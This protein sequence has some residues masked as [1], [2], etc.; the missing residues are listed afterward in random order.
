MK[1]IFLIFILLFVLPID[2]KADIIKYKWYQITEENVSYVKEN[3]CN[4]I[5]DKKSYKENILYENEIDTDIYENRSDVYFKKQTKNK[6][7]DTEYIKYVGIKNA[8]SFNNYLSLSNILIFNKDTGEELTYNYGDSNNVGNLNN[9]IATK[10]HLVFFDNGYLLLVLDNK[11]HKDKLE[12][13]LNFNN[14]DFMNLISL[15]ASSDMNISTYT[16]TLNNSTPKTSNHALDSFN[17]TT[18]YQVTLYIY[19]EKTY[20]CYKEKRNYKEGYHEHL[21]NYIKD[22]EKFI[23]IKEKNKQANVPIN[24]LEYQ[25]NNINDEYVMYE[26]LDNISVEDEMLNDV[27]KEE[28]NIVNKK[29]KK[30]NKEKNKINI[31]YLILT[32]F[33][34]TIIFS[35]LYFVKKCRTK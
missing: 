5:L 12:I 17:L 8:T 15:F 24:Y 10:N 1:K 26:I 19:Y 20:K 33:V 27:I 22:K 3:E 13:Q 9:Y 4:N 23:I 2:S 34:I 18:D 16:K 31:F 28:K 35:A 21:D 11:I 32:L 6:V 7:L 14:P 25:M 29:P 30:I